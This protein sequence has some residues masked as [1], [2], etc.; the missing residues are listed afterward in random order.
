MLRQILFKLLN[1][2]LATLVLCLTQNVAC[3]LHAPFSDDEAASEALAHNKYLGA[4]TCQSCHTKPIA[5][6]DF[7]LLTE[8]TTWRTEDRHSLAYAA[9]LNSTGRRIG[10]L[11]ANDEQ[12]AQKPEAGCLNCHAMNFPNRQGEGFSPRDGVSCDGCHGPS[13]KW[14]GP[15]FAQFESW[16]KKTPIEKQREGMR[17][18]RDPATRSALCLSCH[19]GNAEEGKVVTHA[20]YAAGHP[21]LPDVEVASLSK[22]LPQHWR[23]LKKVP[24]LMDSKTPTAVRELYHYDLADFQNTRL[25]IVSSG[26]ALAHQMKFLSERSTD[27]NIADAKKRWPEMSLPGFE[28]QST[29]DLWPQIAMANLDCYACHHDLKKPSW[30]QERGYDFRLLDGQAVPGVPGRIQFQP[31]PLAL[32]QIGL[33]DSTPEAST[34]AG[35]FNELKSGL[36]KLHS[37]NNAR[38]FGDRASV[39]HSSILLKDWSQKIV[40]QR[41]SVAADKLNQTA[42]Q[43]LL[44]GLCK[45]PSDYWPD[46]GSARQIAAAINIVSSEWRPES[47]VEQANQFRK[48]L[49][50]LLVELDLGPLSGPE[51]STLARKKLITE[52]VAMLTKRKIST[53]EDLQ[54]AL[55]TPEAANTQ[56]RDFLL[57]SENGRSSFLDTYEKLLGEQR[58]VSSRAAADYEP[59]RFK[60]K[61]SALA[62]LLPGK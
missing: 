29:D 45:L 40:Q 38:P 23:D 24:Y 60:E 58:L 57:R 46:Y 53:E 4:S 1:S 62:K 50:E 21:P 32:F 2:L 55:L 31:W 6:P 42:L 44:L 34:R 15:H 14:I 33:Q 3:A 20:M 52:Q 19:L 22:R 54:T 47:N 12:F 9:L 36:M 61:L 48:L 56:I 41:L 30:R 17:N 13:E 5:K 10:K 39:N 18:L 43:R 16:R 35:L 25:T 8:F 11:L 49:E 28:G 27:G 26:N 59:E 51:A 7:V 37:A